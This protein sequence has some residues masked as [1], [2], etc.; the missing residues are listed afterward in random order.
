MEMGETGVSERETKSCAFVIII[1]DNNA[2]FIKM[3]REL[4]KKKLGG[5]V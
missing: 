5:V 4:Q 3:H 1:L 2:N